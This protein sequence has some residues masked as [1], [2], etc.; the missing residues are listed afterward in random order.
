MIGQHPGSGPRRTHLEA[1]SFPKISSGLDLRCKAELRAMFAIPYALGMF[2]AD[3]ALSAPRQT[4]WKSPGNAPRNGY[5]AAG[6][7]S[8]DAVSVR[9]CVISPPFFSRP[10]LGVTLA[11]HADLPPIELPSW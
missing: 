8:R 9:A 4:V 7:E 3:L 1:L 6:G 2:V 5:A 11:N 10:V